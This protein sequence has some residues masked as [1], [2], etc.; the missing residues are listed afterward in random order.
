LDEVMRALW[1]RCQG[2]PMTEDD[3]RTVLRELGKRSFD[4]D[5]A[6][7]VHSTVE[8]PLAELLAAHGVHLQAETPQLAQRLGLRVAEN[9]SVQIKTVMRAGPAEHAGM[10]AGDEWLGVEVQGQGW[11]ISKLDDVAFYAG[12]DTS[13]TAVVARDGRLLRLALELPPRSQ[14]AGH[15]RSARV[16]A[17]PDTVSLSATDAAALGRWLG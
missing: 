5:I 8:L 6:Q 2:G 4:A 14:A 3:L 12:G 10:C 15:R 16:T 13:I 9:H 7:W 17:A 11:R 1:K